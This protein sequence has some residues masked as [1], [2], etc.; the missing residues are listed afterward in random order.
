MKRYALIG[1]QLSHS[2]SPM[3][4]R[5]IYKDFDI[6]AEYELLEVKEEELGDVIERLRKKEFSGLNVTIPYK[7]E[8]IKYLDE[9]SEEA[10]AIGSVNTIALV[11]GKIIG[12]NTDY[13][14]FYQSVLNYNIEVK[15]KHCFVLG[16]G[17][18]ALAVYKALKDLGGYVRYVSRNPKNEDM[19]SYR[20]LEEEQ[21]DVL[22]NTTPIG[23]YPNVEE[24]P[25]TDKVIQKAKYVM[26]IIFNPLQTVLLKK[27]DSTMNGLDMLVGQAIK[28]EEIWQNKKLYS[29][30]DLLKRTGDLL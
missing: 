30:R 20:R 13:F 25:V 1:K 26:D 2:F 24:C 10:E 21:I 9:L 12:Y 16:T 7:K 6:C 15:G 18:A 5:E 8:I 3:I 11:H 29:S 22:V 4:H 28:A 27:A 23:M 14:G 17:G 19:I